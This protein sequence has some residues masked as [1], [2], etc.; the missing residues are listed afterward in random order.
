LC[1]IL[2]KGASVERVTIEPRVTIKSVS[3]MNTFIPELLIREWARRTSD[4]FGKA[5]EVLPVHGC[6]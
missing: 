2:K 6:S 1:G 4:R 5:I 3:S